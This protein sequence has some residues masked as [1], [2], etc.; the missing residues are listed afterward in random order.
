MERWLFIQKL[1]KEEEGMKS[2]KLPFVVLLLLFLIAFGAQVQAATKSIQLAPGWNL[3]NFPIQPTNTQV[4]QLFNG[5]D[6]ISVWSWDGENSKWNVY[7]A[8]GDDATQ[9]YANLKG[10]NVLQNINAGEGFWI[11]SGIEQ[12]LSV[13]GSSPSDATHALVKGWNLIG[14]KTDEVKTVSA[15][16]N[17]LNKEGVNAISIWAWNADTMTWKVFLPSFPEDQF[18]AYIQAKGFE[19]LSQVASTEGFWINTDESANPTE[20]PPMVGKVYKTTGENAYIPLP[21]V[22]VFLNGTKI[23]TTDPSGNFE[24]PSDIQ[25]GPDDVITIGSGDQFTISGSQLMGNGLYLFAQDQDKNK[26]T[27]EATPEGQEKPTPKKVTSSDGNASI[28]ITNMKLTKDITVAVTPYKTAISAPNVASIKELDP[29]FMVVAGADVIFVDS[30][31]NNISLQDAGF[32]G[33]VYPQAKNFLGEFTGEAIYNYMGAGDSSKAIGEL[34]LLAYQNGEYTIVGQAEL[35]EETTYAKPSEGQEAVAGEK[36]YYLKAASGVKM[37]GLYPFVFVFKQKYLIGEIEVTVTNNGILYKSDQGEVLVQDDTE[38]KGVVIDESYQDPVKGAMVTT[39]NSDEFAVTD[40]NGKATIKYI[41]PPD[42]PNLAILV[43]KDGYFDANITVNVLDEDKKS[44]L[45]AELP[46]TAAVGGK[47]YDKETEEGIAGAK[48]TLKN[49]IVLDKIVDDGETITVGK[50]ASATYKWEIRKQGTDTWFTIAEEKGKNKITRTEIKQTLIDGW[51]N[52]SDTQKQ[53]FGGNPVGTYDVKITVTHP[54]ENINY[55]ESATGYL[56]ITIDLDKFEETASLSQ[57]LLGLA[58]V[59]GGK[60]LGFY[61]ATGIIS[62][63]YT[64]T[65][66]VDINSWDDAD[67]DNEVDPGEVTTIASMDPIVK[68]PYLP[69]IETTNLIQDNYMT[70]ISGPESWNDQNVP[71]GATYLS[72]GVSIHI[73]FTLTVFDWPGEDGPVKTVS[74]YAEYDLSGDP[75]KTLIIGKLQIIPNTTMAFEEK[76][77]TDENGEFLFAYL[78]PQLSGLLGLYGSADGYKP[79]AIFLT[80][81]DYPLIKGWVTTVNLGLDP[82]EPPPGLPKVPD[83]VETWENATEVSGSYMISSTVG[84][85]EVTGN[86]MEDIQWWLLEN[87][88]NYGPA[89]QQG[90][91]YPLPD[92][93][94]DGT[95]DE[96]AQANL[97]PAFEG[98]NVAWFGS[99]ETYTFSDTT[100]NTSDGYKWG[101]L[102]SPVIDLTNFSYATLEFATWWEVESVDVAKWQYDQMQVLVS[103]PDATED[104]PVTIGDYTFTG[105][106]DWKIVSFLNPDEEVP[107]QSP[108]I[109]YSSG[110]NDVVPIWIKIV[111]NLNPFVGHKIRLQFYFNTVDSLYNGFRGWAVDEIKIKNE[112]SG[113]PFNIYEQGGWW[114]KKAPVR[115]PIE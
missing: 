23:G 109:N 6:Y 74:T 28:T 33:D 100:G 51:N 73:Q 97:L 18:K 39:D 7:L 22:D 99:K 87:P 16:L 95:P 21:D 38:G 31:G 88:E 77:V 110:G 42:N 86:D 83:W 106:E 1:F 45:M 11:N 93:D 92:S 55:V 19:E 63:N 60:D 27:L 29:N 70:L 105:P 5:I 111:A 102:T 112:D 8:S 2:I 115:T 24:L 69:F 54:F 53:A 46:D 98:D 65:W 96:G 13:E 75:V 57:A 104:T 78:D 44:V 56:D 52:L 80:E 91:D 3:I 71:E 84:Q 49:P 101:K 82:I 58:T 64:Y 43:K 10:F 9:T 108:A 4:S 114:W 103:I 47:V 32:Q 26:V 25:I 85:W 34:W 89:A 12:T 90:I 15:I 61:Y 81:D 40:E 107:V 14:A 35:G 36:A 30:E 17:M 79:N 76:K 113:L 94:G 20:T 62:D 72:E 67:S 41:L 59:F 68:V 66:T 48:V 50:D 37:D